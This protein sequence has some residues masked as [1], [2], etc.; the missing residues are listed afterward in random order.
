MSAPTQR[1]VELSRYY[2]MCDERARLVEAVSEALAYLVPHDGDGPCEPARE[3]LESALARVGESALAR[4]G[5]A[6]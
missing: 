6:W 1:A 4:I 2:A 3:V 5:G